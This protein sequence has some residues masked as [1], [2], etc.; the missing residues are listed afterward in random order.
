MDI[1]DWGPVVRGAR[2][3]ILR[4][5]ADGVGDN[6]NGPSLMRS[7]KWV[8]DP[9]GRYYLY[10]AHH[11]GDRIK[12]AVA[13]DVDGPWS[14]H[15][16]GVLHVHQTAFTDHVASPDVIV[17][18]RMRKV[19]LY[20]HGGNSERSEDQSEALALSDDGL[21]FSVIR[22]GLGPFY[23]RVFA[24]RDYWYALV[25]PGVV[26][27]SRDGVQGWQTGPILFPPCVR[28]SAVLVDKDVLYVWH[29]RVGDAPERILLSVVGL[30]GDWTRWRSVGPVTF[31]SPRAPYEGASLP[32]RASVRGAAQEP[33]RELRD[34]AVFTEAGRVWIVYSIA[35]ESGLATAHIPLRALREFGRSLL[36]SAA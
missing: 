18:P 21:R 31:L 4:V 7:P 27:R 19:L 24:W 15:Q 6:I 33:V 23:W 5:G 2:N 20:F 25:M 12:L 29:S 9:L 10:F 14:L 32:T 35:G 22:E 30:A 28:H 8:S 3:P 36:R 16:P 34:P 17:R 26:L 11:S 13:D 1:G